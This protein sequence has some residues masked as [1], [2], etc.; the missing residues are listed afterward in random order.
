MVLPLALCGGSGGQRSPSLVVSIQV[1]VP[2]EF[3]SVLDPPLVYSQRYDG[4]TGHVVGITSHL[5]GESESGGVYVYDFGPPDTSCVQRRPEANIRVYVPYGNLFKFNCDPGSLPDVFDSTIAMCGT[6]SEIDEGDSVGIYFDGKPLVG[7]LYWYACD[8]TSS[9][10]PP[11]YRLS[12]F[13][14]ELQIEP[15]VPVVPMT[16]GALKTRFVPTGP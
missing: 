5:V 1:P 2:N 3:V 8:S 7:N 16:W 14:V 13:T 9:V 12:E 4:P 11:A 10:A 15:T 6:Y